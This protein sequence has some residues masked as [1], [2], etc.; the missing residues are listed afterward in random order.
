VERVVLEGMFHGSS[1][2]LGQM[3]SH[4]VKIGTIVITDD[5]TAER[6]DEEIDRIKEQVRPH[7]RLIESRV[8][9]KVLLTDPWSLEPPVGV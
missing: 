7:A 3:V 8:D 6:S 2:V 1:I 9:A 5:F 4:F